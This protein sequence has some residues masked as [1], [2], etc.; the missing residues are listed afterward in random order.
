[1]SRVHVKLVSELGVGT[2][3]AGVSKAHADVV[4]ISGHDGGTGASPLTSVKHAGAPWELGLAETQQTLLMNGL[5]DRIVVQCRRPAEDGSRCCDR[6]AARCR[7]I[8]LRHRAARRDG[9]CDDARLSP[10][11]LPGRC[12]DAGSRA[13]EEVHG[14]S[15]IRRELLRVHRRRG[16]RI[17]AELGFRS[18][19]DAIGQVE[20]LDM[21]QAIDHWKAD[22]LD[23]L[24]DPVPPAAS[25]GESRATRPV[26]TMGSRRPRH[27]AHREAHGPRDGDAR[28]DLDGRSNV[29]RSV[30]TRLGYE[31]TRRYGEEGLPDDTITISL[32]GSAGNS[33]GAF[34]P[35]GITLLLT[36]DANDY[37]GKGLSGGRIVIGHPSRLPGLAEE[38]GHRRQRHRLRRDR[39]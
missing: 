16:A 28:R 17:L 38:Q 5:R 9:L 1:M 30:G 39:R 34:M 22:G 8:R 33:F 7:R 25:G 27:M 11:H 15:R 32:D 18:L 23:L 31:L 26:R 36:G 10:Q 3:A 6:G 12:G 20:C 19:D 21:Q 4:L 13:S 37:A 29:N 24:T 2:V 35:K 14:D